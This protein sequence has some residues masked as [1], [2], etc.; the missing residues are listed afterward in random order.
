MSSARVIQIP[1]CDRAILSQTLVTTVRLWCGSPIAIDGLTPPLPLLPSVC[2]R[3]NINIERLPEL[4]SR[5]ASRVRVARCLSRK[6]RF[7]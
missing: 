6:I 1:G 3:R 5:I 2:S 7:E 4:P